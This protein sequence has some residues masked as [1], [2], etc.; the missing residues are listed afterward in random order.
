MA[1]DPDERVVMG[2]IVA[3]WGVKGW[4][5]I[6]PYSDERGN[7]CGFPTWLLEKRGKRREIAVAE[8]KVHG[9]HVVARFEGCED[10]DGAEAYRGSEVAL[11]RSELPPPAPNEVYQADLIGLTVLGSKGERL[12]RIVEIVDNPGNPILRVAGEDRERLVPFV[13]PVIRAV[14]VEAG[15]VELDWGA[16]W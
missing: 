2:R 14:D 4:V 11:R 1:R 8:C 15:V 10:R 5:K 12:G 6:E 9:A 7:L 3:P 13:P 16:D